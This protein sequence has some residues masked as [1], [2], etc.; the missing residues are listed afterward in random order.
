MIAPEI[1]PVAISL[2]PLKVHWYGLMYVTAFA[3]AWGL[4][5][6]RARKPGSGWTSEEVGDLIVAGAIGVIVGGRLGYI[7]FY[8]F[9]YYLQNP[10]EIFYVWQGG[11]SF[12]G[13]LLGVVVA[14]AWYA[15]K[16]HRSWATV[17]DFQAPLVPLGLGAGRLGNF[18]NQE[19][20]GKVSDVPWAM[21]F[22]TGGPL[23]RHP[24]QLY[25]FALEGIVLFVIIWWFSSRARPPWAVS[26]LFA[27]FYGL[28]R[29]LVEFYRKPDAHLGYLAF[30]WFTMG[31]LL[32]LPL[33]LVGVGVFWW[34]Y[35][36]TDT[37][38][39]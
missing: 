13:G 34:S 1:N 18:I 30:D 6:L 28:F 36:R 19:L 7:L 37:A 22:R 20:W 9:G 25:E 5:A 16:T 10:L 15:H 24:S 31:Q 17:L 21:V 38:T 14:M 4:G 11:M 29:F 2:G 26:A 12:H 39:S 32:S 33:I 35:R 3:I 27:I 8:K 23:P